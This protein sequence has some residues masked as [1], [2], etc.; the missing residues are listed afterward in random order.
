MA[1]HFRLDLLTFRCAKTE[2][3]ALFFSG[4]EAPSVS[5]F[6]ILCVCVCLI[7]QLCII[8]ATMDLSAK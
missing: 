1:D 3:E 7:F 8:F 6:P 2:E 4:G 5:M